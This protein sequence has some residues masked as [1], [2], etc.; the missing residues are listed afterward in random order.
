MS[1]VMIECQ[2]LTKS[3]RKG[4][5]LVTPLEH[6]DLSVNQLTS[7]PEELG[8]CTQLQ[9]LTLSTNDLKRLPESLGNLGQLVTLKNFGSC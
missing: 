8:M 9:D 2:G 1:E 6:L 3:Y 7:L 4:S 5:N